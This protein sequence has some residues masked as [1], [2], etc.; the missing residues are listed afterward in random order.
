MGDTITLHELYKIRK[1]KDK[2]HIETFK[3]ITGLINKKI[4]RIAEA[5]GFN[6]F[7]EVPPMLLGMPLYDIEE[8]MKYITTIYRKAGFLVQILPPPNNKVL[9]ISWKIDDVSTKYKKLY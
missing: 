3:S 8:C 4:K 9:Y 2:R 6:I 5:G 1:E 7:Y